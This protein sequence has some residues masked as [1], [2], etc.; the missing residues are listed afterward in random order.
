MWTLFFG[1]YVNATP[2]CLWFLCY[3][4]QTNVTQ[5]KH[6]EDPI[7][8]VPG[9][10][11]SWKKNGYLTTSGHSLLI[12]NG[13]EHVKHINSKRGVPE[14]GG[15]DTSCLKIGVKVE[16][17]EKLL[18]FKVNINYFSIRFFF[19]LQQNY[20]DEIFFWSWY[21]YWNR[22]FSQLIIIVTYRRQ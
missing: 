8:S 14:M 7:L 19:I 22:A 13:S 10:I 12:K 4:R 15:S 2:V 20:K 16:H 21:P 11:M 17:R 1:V 3:Q 6:S 5:T 9:R 18:D